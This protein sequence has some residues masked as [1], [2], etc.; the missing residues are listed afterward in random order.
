MM[1]TETAAVT[2]ESGSQVSAIGAERDDALQSNSW[3]GTVAG[4]A[5]SMMTAEA[6]EETI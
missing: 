5:C 6:E 1:R 4:S 2:C 3:S